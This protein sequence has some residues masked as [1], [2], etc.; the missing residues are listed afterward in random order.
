VSRSGVRYDI[1]AVVSVD[2]RG[3]VVLPKE[4]REA[5][6]LEAGSKLAVVIKHSGD[7]PCCVNL[8]PTRSL[9]DG[10]RDVLD[11]EPTPRRK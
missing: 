11:P 4:V 1:E 6:A 7:V 9:E 8:V 10:L 3:Q 2:A 5:L